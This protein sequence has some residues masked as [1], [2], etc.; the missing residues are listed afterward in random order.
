MKELKD[1]KVIPG[2]HIATQHRP[3]ISDLALNVKCNSK[4]KLQGL[5]KIKWFRLKDEELKR[6]FMERVLGEIEYEIHDINEWWEKTVEIIL[7]HAKEILGESNGKIWENKETWWFN[8]DV[9]NATRR[10]KEAKKRWEE[11][12]DEGDRALLRERN[13]E[14]KRTVA[15][16]RSEAYDEL[17]KVL[18][19]VEGQR[20]IFRLANSRNRST[21]DMTHIRQIKG[22]DGNVIRKERDIIKRW[23]EYFEKLLNE[24]NERLIRGDGIPNF[25]VAPEISKEEV[26]AALAKMKNGKAVGPDGVPAEAWKALGEAGINILWRLMKRIMELETIPEKWRESTLI[27]IYKEKGDIQSCKNYRGIKLMSHTLKIFERIID[28]RLR[29][30][31]ML[32]KQQL[33]FMKGVGTV[34]G[35]FS[36]RQLMEKCRE[37][38]KVLH[39]VFI[40]LEKAYD[41]VPRQEIWRS[42]RERGV[43]EKYV[44][45]IK[46]TYRDVTTSVRST[47]GTTSG[48]QV[49]VGLH[50]GSALSPILFNIVLDVLTEDVRGD[51][52]WC[53]FYADDIV[54]A[55]ESRE[56]L[57]RRL[58][59][60]R[61]ALESRGLKISREKTEYMTNGLDED[62]QA[63]I[64][65]GETNIKR[66]H[67]FKYLGSTM[68]ME[69]EMDS[70]MKHRVLSGEKCLVCCVIKECP[71]N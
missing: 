41:R 13:K 20:R 33:G 59:G 39:M 28:G 58:E 37:R 45:V 17:Y 70:E 50:Q 29:Q 35:I 11:T 66:V 53:M 54:L 14:A 48:F 25:G 69:G 15:I 1:T 22:E 43:M 40:D 7:R 44:R 9:Q 46:E 6:T 57:E 38:Q 56:E 3:V 2:D 47:A 12:Q 24:E 71:S 30:E 61:Y 32:G 23:K 49:R 68:N 52:P 8:D 26:R 65:L 19:T 55:A 10:K 63:T 60:W 64:R 31:V 5:K 27:P 18:E 21:K 42:L 51:P 34:D 62:Q 36:L 67:K 4:R 16:A